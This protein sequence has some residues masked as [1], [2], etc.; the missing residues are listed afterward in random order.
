MK[1]NLYH[2]SKL[3]QIT[4][5]NNILFNVKQLTNIFNT[6]YNLV[7]IYILDILFLIK[8]AHLETI[9]IILDETSLHLRLDPY[10][11]IK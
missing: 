5:L 10:K 1:N 6:F 11:L 7:F 4:N 2:K 9:E 3:N 8:N